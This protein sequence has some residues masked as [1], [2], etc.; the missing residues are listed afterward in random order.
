MSFTQLL[1]LTGVV[2][3]VPMIP[4]YILFKFLP[5]SAIGKG[6]LQ[7]LH[8]NFTGAFAGYFMVVL[9]AIPFTQYSQTKARQEKIDDLERQLRLSGMRQTF[10]AYLV[11]GRIEVAPGSPD[12]DVNS[13]S[14]TVFPPLVGMSP[15]DK[16]FWTVVPVQKNNFGRI[17]TLQIRSLDFLPAEVHL[18]GD[19]LL[20][21]TVRT[22]VD[23]SSQIIYIKDPIVLRRPQR[24]YRSGAAHHL[25][26]VVP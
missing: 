4:A 18:L 12:V 1:V 19:S 9:V 8:V 21:A 10:Q 26:R 15:G 13:V 6:P 22:V 5:S 24:P 3:L 7:G 20:K 2:L 17:A 16:T 11:Q 14:I 23:T 25:T